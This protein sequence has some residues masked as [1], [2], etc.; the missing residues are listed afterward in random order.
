MGGTGQESGSG[1]YKHYT[2][3]TATREGTET[4]ENVDEMPAVLRATCMKVLDGND[5]ATLIIADQRGLEAWRA[6]QQARL[7]QPAPAA[8][9]PPRGALRLR[10]RVSQ[11]IPWRL[12]LELIGCGA[13]ALAIWLLAIR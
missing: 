1:V 7:A 5:T 11:R 8:G 3:L 10:I 12:A 13:A 9:K 6:A 4:F 2:I